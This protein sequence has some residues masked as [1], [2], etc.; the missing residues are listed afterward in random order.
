MEKI[1]LDTLTEE[2]KFKHA[3]VYT[4]AKSPNIAIV[5]ATAN[6]IPLEPFKEV[7]NFIGE[8]TAKRGIT[9]L[10]FDKRKLSVFHQPSMEWYFIEWKEKTFDLGLKTHRKILPVDDIFRQSVRIG[11]EKI[12]KAYPTKKFNSMDIQYFETVEEAIQK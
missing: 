3:T 9:K 7:F 8:L 5:E 1:T 10:I 4:V 11:R 12:N 2:K 6:Y